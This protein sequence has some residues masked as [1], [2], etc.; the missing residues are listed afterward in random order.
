MTDIAD[1]LQC[2]V[3]GA[4]LRWLEASELVTLQGLMSSGQV[5]HLDGSAV[6]ISV[7]SALGTVEG[8]VFYPVVDGIFV[9]L[10]SLALARTDQVEQL[11]AGTL[12]PDTAK[13]KQFYDEIGWAG[14]QKGGFEDAKRWEDLRPVSADYIH[15][16]HLRVNRYLSQQGR[17][18][19]DI[20]SGPIQY[21]DY[22]TYS[23]NYEKRICADISMTALKAA[24]QRLRD[25]GVY[26]QCDITRLPFKTNSLDGFVSLHTIYHVPA[27]RQLM[28]FRELERALMPGKSGAVIYSW[29]THN[30]LITFLEEFT[31]KELIK[32]C[33]PETI[34]N[35]LRKKPLGEGRPAY[36]PLFFA[37]HD[38]AWFRAEV[39]SHEGWTVWVWRFASVP[40]LKRY[41]HD[42]RMGRSLLSLLYW[43]EERMPHVMG[44][45]GLYPLLVFRK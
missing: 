24:R 15:K 9:L 1:I 44:R 25:K 36:I 45:V 13:V 37:P 19:L 38:H 22:L 40:L 42:G 14:D 26:V 33:L 31:W 28:A 29:G 32:R 34:L 23:T 27:D 16:C 21:D 17:Y 12:A 5:K 41:A 20:A 7:T 43:L 35:A 39:A 18:L 11:A 8:R 4:A 2:P 6:Q 10:P 30:K 3:T